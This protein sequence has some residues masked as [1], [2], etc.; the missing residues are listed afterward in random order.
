MGYEDFKSW[1]LGVELFIKYGGLKGIKI[2]LC[3]ILA[4]FLVCLKD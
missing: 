1:L 2:V 4:I 3:G